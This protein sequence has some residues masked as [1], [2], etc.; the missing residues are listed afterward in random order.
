MCLNS[1]P[2]SSSFQ[3]NVPN[4]TDT[5]KSIL[6]DNEVDAADIEQQKTN[7]YEIGKK[8]ELGH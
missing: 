7:R 3:T 5:I 6:S 8:K 2:S 4:E 1:W